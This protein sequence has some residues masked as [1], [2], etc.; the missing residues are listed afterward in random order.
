MLSCVSGGRGWFCA[1]GCL[2]GRGHGHS[3]ECLGQCVQ[4]VSLDKGAGP[5]VTVGVLQ[6]LQ[7]V[8]NRV[9]AQCVDAL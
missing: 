2:P 4:K 8:L 1:S 6:R 7:H 3:R 9:C 5:H